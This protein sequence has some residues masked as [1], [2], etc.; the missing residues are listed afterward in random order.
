VRSFPDSAA[1]PNLEAADFGLI[2]G[3]ATLSHLQAFLSR[4][5]AKHERLQRISATVYGAI[6]MDEKSSPPWYR[7]ELNNSSMTLD[8]LSFERTIVKALPTVVYLHFDGELDWQRA[9]QGTFSRLRVLDMRNS[10]S[11]D[12][13]MT[14]DVAKHIASSFPNLEQLMVTYIWL[15]AVTILFS[16]L[17]R[18]WNVNGYPGSDDYTRKPLGGKALVEYM[19]TRLHK[20]PRRPM[21]FASGNHTFFLRDLVSDS[22]QMELQAAYPDIVAIRWSTKA[23]SP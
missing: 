22:E 13:P 6:N 17:P 9:V 2:N 18:L 1:W 10:Y 23:A 4:F 11:S 16:H 3:S 14:A 12:Q 8:R 7:L 21:T 5:L 19:V 20:Y 15:P